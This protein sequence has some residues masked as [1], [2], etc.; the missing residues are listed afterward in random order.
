MNW[1]N[2]C[3]AG[4]LCECTQQH[5]TRFPPADRADGCGDNWYLFHNY[6]GEYGSYTITYGGLRKLQKKII[7]A[8]WV[9]W[10]FQQINHPCLGYPPI[11]GTPQWYHGWNHQL[12]RWRHS[13]GEAPSLRVGQQVAEVW[14]AARAFWTEMTWI[15]SWK[16]GYSFYGNFMIKVNIYI[17][18]TSH[19][20]FYAILMI[21]YDNLMVTFPQQLV[22]YGNFIV[23]VS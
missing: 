8:I 2:S 20:V 17:V 7:H 9:S 10:I 1:Q 13:S 18:S 21:T 14:A 22:I 15:S 3:Q 12:P 19:V 23:D 11:D 4:Q 6:I 16:S 5:R